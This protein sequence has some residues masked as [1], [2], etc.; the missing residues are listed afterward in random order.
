[1][2]HFM[3]SQDKDFLDITLN[4]SVLFSNHFRLEV[5]IL[6]DAVSHHK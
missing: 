4:N 3:L 1:M 6:V 2:L 5:S